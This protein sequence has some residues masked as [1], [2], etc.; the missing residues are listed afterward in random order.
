MSIGGT[1]GEVILKMTF[2]N[3]GYVRILRR[4]CND[5]FFK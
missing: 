4:R 5:E 1:F 3:K 2:F